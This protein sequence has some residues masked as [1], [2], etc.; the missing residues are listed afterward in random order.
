MFVVLCLL[1]K[2]Y[3]KKNVRY[4]FHSTALLFD[5]KAWQFHIYIA[6]EWFST[7]TTKNVQI[8]NGNSLNVTKLSERVFFLTCSPALFLPLVDPLSLRDAYD[9]RYQV[10]SDV[11]F[12]EILKL[13]LVLL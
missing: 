11:Y 6:N 3:L 1:K 5:A 8:S 12:G 4:A 7:T 2:K 10:R 9:T 13:F